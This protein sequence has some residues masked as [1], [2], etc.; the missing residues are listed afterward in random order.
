MS[1]FQLCCSE[2]MS[3]CQRVQCT[4]TCEAVPTVAVTGSVHYRITRHMGFVPARC[5]HMTAFLLNHSKS[6]LWSS[7]EFCH[8]WHLIWHKV[9]VSQRDSCCNFIKCLGTKLNLK[10]FE[11]LTAWIRAVS[12]PWVVELCGVDCSIS[13]LVEGTPM[14]RL[15]CY[16]AIGREEE[17]EPCLL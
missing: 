7:K 10:T 5:G 11:I 8:S 1:Y 3:H 13:G 6:L 16:L 4:C 17:G 2:S 9:T 15:L 14:S 12:A